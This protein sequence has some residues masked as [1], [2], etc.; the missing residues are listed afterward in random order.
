VYRN[1]H[2]SG[3]AQ[4]PDAWLEAVRHIEPH[5]EIVYLEGG[6]WALG[7]WSP[8]T[9]QRRLR[10]KKIMAQESA[11]PLDERRPGQYRLAQAALQG[12]RIINTYTYREFDSGY[13]VQDFRV[14][15]FVYRKN[16]DEKFEA[17]LNAAML[18]PD[19]PARDA[20]LAD[21]AAYRARDA[22]AYAMRG[23]KHFL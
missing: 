10:A 9:M 4:A 2:V 14:A 15:D 7:S 5:A 1:V 8:S 6:Q 11:K 17:N 21:E 18:H 13:A 12:F 16:R 23:R 3:N 19:D 20:E 22:W